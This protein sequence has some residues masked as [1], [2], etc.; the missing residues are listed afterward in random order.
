M[1]QKSLEEKML[2]HM[3]TCDTGQNRH[4]VLYSAFKIKVFY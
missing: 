2:K 4:A 3:M 1:L